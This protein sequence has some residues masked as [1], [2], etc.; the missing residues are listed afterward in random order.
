[1]PRELCMLLTAKIRKLGCSRRYAE[2][3][4]RFLVAIVVLVFAFM[5]MLEVPAMVLWERPVR[6]DTCAGEPF[7]IAVFPAAYG[8]QR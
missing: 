7:D 4:V 1:M 3:I 2:R 8:I 5:G 6:M